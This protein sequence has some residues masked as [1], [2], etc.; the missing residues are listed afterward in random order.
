V[1]EGDLVA[2]TSWSLSDLGQLQTTLSGLIRLRSGGPGISVAAS[3]GISTAKDVVHAV[4]AGAD[5]AMV[6]SEIYRT[7]PDA[8]AH[9]LEGIVHYLQRSRLDSFEEFVADRKA[10]TGGVQA[11][12]DQVRPMIRRDAAH[13]P[14]PHT[15]QRQGD[16]WGH[17]QR[18]PLDD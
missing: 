15:I 2:T 7:G 1:Y 17:A 14:H 4:I 10:H 12:Q 6:T 13:D 5:I 3:G 18:S 8:I 16:R 11:R 9:I